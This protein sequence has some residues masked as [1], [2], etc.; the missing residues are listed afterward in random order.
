MLGFGLGFR[1]EFANFVLSG[2]PQVDWFEFIT[3]NCFI[4]GGR[5]RRIL[6]EVRANY[7][8]VLHGVSLSIGSAE[9]IDQAYL[10]RL[11]R[12]IREIEPEWVSDHLCWTGLGQHNSHDLLPMPFN[13]ESLEHLCG[14]I[15]EVQEIL[16]RPMV[17]E[18]LSA[19]LDFR[20]SE[21][22][23]SEFI[24]GILE[25]TGCYLLLDINN[26]Y[27]SS[28]N[29]DRNPFEF[30]EKLKPDRVKQIH[31]A[32]H[33][34]CGEFLFDTHDQEIHD[35]VWKLYAQAIKR[36]GPVPTMIERDEKI[37]EFAKLVDELQMARLIHEK[38][39]PSG[40]LKREY[41]SDPN[42]DSEPS[43]P[44]IVSE[45]GASL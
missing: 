37:P 43:Q 8:I 3:E 21:M 38:V 35:E 28:F 32:G 5:P 16:G 27:I 10:Q 40:Q 25:R 20:A 4:E 31:L 7:P 19:Y 9:P 12:L 34:D 13:R 36:L 39:L 22:S 2:K 30:L 29:L 33:R 24:S 26:L 45:P 41:R 14:R 23:E 6:H 42:L 11:K 44:V 18:N 1:H 17:F 15:Q